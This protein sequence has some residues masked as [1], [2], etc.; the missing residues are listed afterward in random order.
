M[1][2]IR[3]KFVEVSRNHIFN[4]RCTKKIIKIAEIIITDN[5]KNAMQLFE[6]R[7]ILKMFKVQL[8]GTN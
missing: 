8:S 1:T 3:K 6:S 2:G 5:L 7:F 4:Y